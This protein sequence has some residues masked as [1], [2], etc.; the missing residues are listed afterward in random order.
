LLRAIF[1]AGYPGRSRIPIIGLIAGLGKHHGNISRCRHL[2]VK[3]HR[4]FRTRSGA[5]TGVAWRVQTLNHFSASFTSHCFPGRS[6]MPII[7]PT[8]GIEKHLGVG[9]LEPGMEHTRG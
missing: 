8:A 4:L 3:G 9:F 1:C 7:G 6:K 5:H 2:P